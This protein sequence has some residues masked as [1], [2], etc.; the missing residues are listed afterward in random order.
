MPIKQTY[1]FQG[2]SFGI[3]DARWLGE[4]DPNHYFDGEVKKEIQFDLGT[5]PKNDGSNIMKLC[6]H[7][8]EY[9]T[10]IEAQS[11][12]DLGF[13]GYMH[14][15]RFNLSI[16]L[17]KIYRVYVKYTITNDNKDWTSFG[18]QKTNIPF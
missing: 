2:F 4:V 8:Y 14:V 17:D 1:N 9:I 18:Y 12:Y 15:V 6:T 13:G 5:T 3:D 16:N 10:D 11:Y 7:A